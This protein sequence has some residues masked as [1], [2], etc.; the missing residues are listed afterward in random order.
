MQ[1][2]ARPPTFRGG[3]IRL[4]VKEKTMKQ[5]IR[6]AG[7]VLAVVALAAQVPALAVTAFASKDEAIAMVK[8]GVAYIKGNGRDKGYAEITNKKGQFDRLVLGGE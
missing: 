6:C 2:C 3:S 1:T 4:P 8:K 5:L 7:G